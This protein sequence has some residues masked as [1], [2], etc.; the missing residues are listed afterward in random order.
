MEDRHIISS[1]ISDAETG[2]HL[3][4]DHYHRDGHAFAVLTCCELIRSNYTLQCS[5]EQT[6]K[7][8]YD[9]CFLPNEFPYVEPYL[10]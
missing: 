8:R 9:I 1:P 4:G 2:T 6:C 3:L 5:S 10:Q 7:P